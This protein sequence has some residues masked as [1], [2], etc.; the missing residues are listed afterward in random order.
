MAAADMR[1]ATRGAFVTWHLTPRDPEGEWANVSEFP[2]K[3]CMIEGGMAELRGCMSKDGA[4]MTLVDEHDTP[5]K[6]PSIFNLTLNPLFIRPV[7][8][9]GDASATVSIVATKGA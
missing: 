3:T 1:A 8:I 5:I 4:E 9:A 6:S 2:L 7:L